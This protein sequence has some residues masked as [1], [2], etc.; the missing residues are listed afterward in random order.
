METL[1]AIVYKSTGSWYK[2]VAE[3]NEV[4]ECRIRGKIRLKGLKT[5]NPVAVGDTVHILPE[6]EE[7][8]AVITHIDERSNYI[9]RKASNLSKQYHIIAANIDQALLIVSLTAPK[10]PF[11][12]IDRF[13]VTCEAYR[14]PVHIIFNKVDI[15]GE[16]ELMDMFY[17]KKAYGDI[18]YPCTEVSAK[19]G[20]NID[21]VAALLKDK[22][23]LLSGNSGVGKSTIVNRIDNNLELKTAEV[24]DYHKKGKHTTTFAE[25]YDLHDGGQIIDTPGIKGFGII[26]IDKEELFHFF[27][28]IFKEAENCQFHNCTHIHEPKCAVKEAVEIEKI[29][30]LRYE[31]YVSLFFDD[32]TKY[33]Q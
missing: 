24:S 30:S 4:Y 8:K 27:P 33:R 15:Y 18:G 29:S 14:I 21:K 28:E 12:F 11:A 13:L 2:V 26:D 10:T 3:N 1:N 22:R 31:N 25:M 17:L 9:I 32:D 20:K 19:E 5:T 6:A 16:D 7:G 23:T